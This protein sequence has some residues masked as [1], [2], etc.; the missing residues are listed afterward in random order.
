MAAIHQLH[1]K[2]K[3]RPS[4]ARPQLLVSLALLAV[5]LGSISARGQST[6]STAR[7]D[8]VYANASMVDL[9]APGAYFRTDDGLEI[10]PWEK[11]SKFQA[12]TIRHSFQ[13]ELDNIRL[14]AFWIEGEVF[15]NLEE[16]IV[17]IA[18]LE[19]DDVDLEKGNLAHKRGAEILTGLALVED[20]PRNLQEGDPVKILAYPQGKIFPYKLGFGKKD[21]PVFTMARPSWAKPSEWTDRKGRKIQ[22]ELVE[23]ASGQCRFR[24]DDREFLY[25]LDQLS[26]PDR[27]RAIAQQSLMRVIPLPEG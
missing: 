21:V 13:E 1:D 24:R 10:V 4:L 9:G 5:L 7:K 23:V 15:S 12:A 3:R 2:G 14:R 26:E 11:L 27:E 8:R 17:V 19:E 20:L 22:A 6:A 16:G 25:P 18:L